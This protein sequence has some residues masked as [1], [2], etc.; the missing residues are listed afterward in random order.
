MYVNVSRFTPLSYNFFLNHDA[1][2]WKKQPLK[3]CNSQKSSFPD[4]ASSSLKKKD[5]QSTK[6][7]THP[8]GGDFTV[9]RWLLSIVQQ[10]VEKV[11]HVGDGHYSVL[12]H[13][14][15]EIIIRSCSW[16]DQVN[17]PGH[18]ANADGAVA[19]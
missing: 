3:I 1:F 11:R 17:E 2:L 13:V 5:A 6:R 16:Q 19:I 10:Y 14:G 8:C 15:N 18:I 7:F 4:W 9:N 12:V